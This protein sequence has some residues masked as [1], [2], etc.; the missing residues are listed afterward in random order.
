MRVHAF[1]RFLGMGL[2]ALSLAACANN[3]LPADAPDMGTFRLGHNIVVADG[4]V[5]SPVSR[6]ATPEQWEE[7]VFKAI[8]DRLDGYQ[9]QGLFHLGVTVQGYALAPPGIPLVLSPKSVLIMAVNV[10]DDSQGKKLTE[11][12]HQITVFEGLDGDTVIGSGLTK[13]K[14]QQI[15]TLSFNAA[16]EIQEWLI[17]NKDTW[18]ITTSDR[19]VDTPVEDVATPETNVETP[20]AALSE[21]TDAAPADVPQPQNGLAA[22]AP[23][24]A[25]ASAPSSAVVP[26]AQD[27]R[28]GVPQLNTG[29]S[30]GGSGS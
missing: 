5:K 25:P 8:D 4:A 9:G 30:L 24:A 3:E 12:A 10:W 22:D 7:A 17:E 26:G 6:E 27:V 20:V 28:I 16:R 11:E 14:E 23:D 15:E 19:I 1:I 2:F 18:L 29:N 21:T 13:T